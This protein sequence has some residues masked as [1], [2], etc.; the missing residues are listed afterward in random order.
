MQSQQ[1][2]KEKKNPFS[3]HFMPG[4]GGNFFCR[5]LNFHPEINWHE[6][7]I[8]STYQQKYEILNY[9]AVINRRTPLESN[10]T[11]FEGKYGFQGHWPESKS[12]IPNRI[13]Y[14]HENTR[15]D[16]RLTNHSK[17]EWD[18]ARRQLL[19]KNSTFCMSWMKTGLVDKHEVGVPLRNLWDFKKLCSSLKD[20]ESH[21]QVV[22]STEECM[23]W[24]EK[25]WNEWK[26]TW[27]PK[28]IETV[29]DKIYYGPKD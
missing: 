23:G 27:A 17:E 22:A 28:E 5:M 25:M 6:D 1:H 15:C 21:M 10:W 16:I 8:N 12:D 2:T 29:I 20:V 11:E 18:W 26:M 14:S 7:C 24:R 4:A 9:Q 13:Y 19:W 3:L